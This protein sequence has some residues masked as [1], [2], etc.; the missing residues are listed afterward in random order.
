KTDLAAGQKATASNTRQNDAAFSP[1]RVLDGNPDTY[2]ATDDEQ[3]SGWLEVDLGD[4]RTFNIAC[5]QEAIALGQRV[6]SYAV[7]YWDGRAWQT[8]SKGTTIGH[9]KLDRFEPV[10]AQRV[11]L[12]VDKA[13]AC[14][15]ISTFGL[16]FAR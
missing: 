1:D 7:Q 10:T 15:T 4:P 14:P 16:Y 8:A 2:W 12:V 13:L 9:K 3:T 11:R 6:E 5:M